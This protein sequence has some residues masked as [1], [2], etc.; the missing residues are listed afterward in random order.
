MNN[1]KVMSR[2][3]RLASGKL[4]QLIMSMAIP[5]IL[6]QFINLMYN[7]VDK[8]YIGRIPNV[9]TD[10]LGGIGITHSIII[11]IAAFSQIVS[12]GGAPLAAIALGKGDRKRA[13]K[14]LANGLTM[15]I[16]F[17]ALCMLVTY[18]F[19][20]PLLNLI[21][22]TDDNFKY[23]S[24]YLSV[25]LIGTIFVH[26][27]VGLN[28]FITCQGR[29]G[30]AMM[31][32]LIGAVMN[33]ALDPIFIFVFDM[34]VM[35]AALAT[36]IS[37]AASAIWI[38]SFLFS[39][40]ATLRIK[41]ALLKPDPKIIGAV[42]SLGVAPFVMASTESFVGFV[43]NSGLRTYGGNIYISALTLMQSAI[44]IVGVPL[45]GFTQ[46]VTPVISYNYGAGNKK[47]VKDAFFISLAIMFT[48][49]FVVIMSMILLPELFAS[50]FTSDKSL[51]AVVK[52][53][54]PMFLAG[55]TIFGLQ[56]ACQ[57]TFVALGQSVISLFIALL[58][59]VIL[60]IPLAIILPNF[61]TPKVNGV[62]LAE[63]IADATCALL[64]T[65]IFFLMFKKMLSKC[66]K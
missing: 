23:A 62:F 1:T 14:I 56:R 22:A 5:A 6:A 36:V 52:E 11:L 59:K 42:C 34:G 61:V 29:S 13:E 33:I 57:S 3:E 51:I 43:L 41:L 60:L 15:L 37:Q 44:Q 32:V 7:I 10:A 2:E 38:L 49:N 48:F 63:P 45:S 50:I 31:S 39:K 24:D 8:I 19:K 4:F 28:A 47:R 18:I 53:I 17:T 26:I 12:G 21:G 40:K 16:S 27:T 58:R 55:M 9:G 54:M 30:I 46:G 35:G 25:Y 66:D 65:A 64:C 20:D